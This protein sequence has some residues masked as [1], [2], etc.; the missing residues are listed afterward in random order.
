MNTNAKL[1]GS[2]AFL[3]LASAVALSACSDETTSSGSASTSTSTSTSGSATTGSTGSGSTGGMG[4]EGQG[5]AG[6]GG[7]GQGGAGQGGGGG[8]SPGAKAEAKMEAK[9]GSQATGTAVFSMAADG[10]VTLTVN[11]QNVTP[12]GK[13]GMHIHQN[14]DCSHQMGDSAGG[15][16]NPYSKDHGK[17]GEGSFHLGD[18]GNIE[19]KADGTGSLTMT[20]DLWAV[21]DGSMD[22]VV[23]HAVILHANEDNLKPDANPGGR[24]ACG[25]ITK[26]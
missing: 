26:Q 2:I 9:S 11:V 8:G 17:F 25:V 10:K 20:T 6:Q 19:I 22:D 1:V 12:A 7:A 23:T 13:H 15:H 16:W 3:A 4:G 21:G 5:G 24:I 18:I 14:G